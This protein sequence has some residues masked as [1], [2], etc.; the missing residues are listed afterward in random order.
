LH[1]AILRSP[2]AHAKILSV[3]MEG[4][5]A[6][7]GVDCLVIGEDARRWTGPFAVAVKTPMRHGCLAVDRVC[8]VGERW[9]WRWRAIGTPPRMR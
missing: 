6:L 3:D 4:A 5:L 1:A 2:H 9:R 8:H 7:P